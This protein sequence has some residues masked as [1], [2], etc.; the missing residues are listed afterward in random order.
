MDQPTRR[1]LLAERLS[2]VN[3]GTG[4]G[5][6]ELL[7]RVA[8]D[9]ALRNLVSR[10]VPEGTY[11]NAAAV[12]DVIPEQAWQDAQGNSWQ[13]STSTGATSKTSL[14]SA[15]ATGEG[16]SQ[17]TENSAAEGDNQVPGRLRQVAGQV[18]GA[19]QGIGHSASSL[20]GQARQALGAVTAKVPAEDLRTQASGSVEK[21]KEIVTPLT[22]G[23]ASVADRA[24]QAGAQGRDQV[25]SIT[26][27]VGE[28]ARPAREQPQQPPQGS[29][30]SGNKRRT[31]I[32]VALSSLMEGL[33]QAYN[34]QPIKA[35]GFLVAGL[36]LSTLSGLNTWLAQRVFRAKGAR[37]GPERI[38]PL[39]L[40]LWALT[41]VLNLWDAWNTARSRQSATRS[42]RAAPAAG[43]GSMS[44]QTWDDVAL[45]GP[46][47]ESAATQTTDEFP[48]VRPT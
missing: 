3:W 15:G 43:L 5:T 45:T 23:A 1:A 24:K 22:Q 4:I 37:I 2:E 12:L 30:P 6:V 17:A 21:A 42:L 11:L 10:Y 41:F 26:T 27:K 16:S 36:S 40:G 46:A 25:L 7:E 33:G 47:P 19:A 29:T 28:R 18:A 35:S 38:R 14:F 13:G 39:L 9:E 48:T 32:P 8:D 31:V 34:R 44:P 20:P